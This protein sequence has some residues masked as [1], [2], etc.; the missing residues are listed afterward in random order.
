MKNSYATDG[1]VTKIV[2]FGRQGV[3]LTT[4]IDTADLPLVE[5]RSWRASYD[6]TTGRYYVAASRGR[7][8]HRLLLDPPSDMQVD[9]I[10]H[11]TLDNRRSNLRIVTASENQLNR[12]GAQKNNKSC[13][14][15]GVT[16]NRHHN[17]WMA[18]LGV[19]RRRIFLGYFADAESAHIAYQEALSQ[20]RTG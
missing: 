7:L 3:P 10:N 4:L 20:Y 1:E 17:R 13:G 8:L 2:I 16:W 15:R 19:N 12:V 6:R 9:H 5:E 14:L 18:Q 11:D